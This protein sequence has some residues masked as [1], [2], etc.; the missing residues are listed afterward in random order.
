VGGGA[1]SARPGAQAPV[2]ADFRQ[3]LERL[4]AVSDL[5][6]LSDLLAW[7]Q[8][9]VMPPRGVESRAEQLATVERLA[10]ELFTSSEIGRLL[11]RLGPLEESR[12][13]DSFDASLIRVTRRE[14][15]KARRV[16]SELH[17]ELA[18]A[19]VAGYR[20]WVE[21]RAAS[22]YGRFRPALARNLELRRRYVECFDGY[23]DPYDVLLDDHEPGMKTAEAGD[24]LARLRGELIP[25]IAAVRQAEPVDSSFLA[26]PF[27]IDAQKRFERAI[28]DAFGFDETAWRLD[29]VVH[30]FASAPGTDDI[31]IA[32]RYSEASL[33]SLFSSMHE[34][35]HGL[36]DHQVDPALE[37]TPLGDGASSGLHESQ[38]R[39]WENLV[40]RG[41]PFWRRFYPLL[42]REFPDRL[43]DVELDAFHRAVNKVEPSLIRVDA[44][45]VT[46]N[47]HIVLRF[48]LER[49]LLDG[50]VSLEELPEAWNAGMHELLGVDVPDDACGVL[51]DVHW[52]DGGFGYFP[53][54]SL[55]NVM[56]VQIWE[57]ARADLGDL[58][59]QIEAGEFGELRRW[60]GERLHRWGRTFTP[61]ETL[62]RAV[63]S[64]LDPEPYVRYMR[65]KAASIYGVG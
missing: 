42:Q 65:E 35:G 53:T 58:D 64:P 22:D 10:H 16:P 52:S 38:S 34:F 55:G 1:E 9:V 18:R 21:A 36:Y 32:T 33:E 13:Y 31:R 54:Y 7:D 11:E 15:E 14:W 27:A 5:R 24:V 51:Q 26:G 12:E 4:A 23:D 30:P 46:Y 47:L 19:G 3:L 28:L 57:R 6:R 41:L 39:L 44:D 40:G 60:L 2:S 63:G 48:E 43:G 56:S 59:A 45:E 8:E 62:E 29:A 50:S 37:R 20:M 61:Q 49:A 17:A 25:L